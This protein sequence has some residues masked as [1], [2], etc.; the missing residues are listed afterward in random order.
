MHAELTLPLSTLWSFLLVLTRVGGALLFV[1]LPGI[2]SGPEP[3]RIVLALGFT[4]ALHPLWPR[5]AVAE[6]GLG[7][8][9][10]WLAAETALGVSVGVAVAFL[11]EGLLVACQVIGI[12]AGYSYA[13]LVDP[14]TQADSNVL[15]VLAHL[16]AGCLFFAFGL[17]RQVLRIFAASLESFPPGTFTLR[18][19]AAES[20][21]GLGA[22]MFT[23]GM[24]LALPVVAL[25]ALADIMLALLGRVHAQLQLLMLA[26]P[27]KMLAALVLL[28][29]VSSL[30]VPL[31]RAGAERTMTALAQMVARVPAM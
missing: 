1:P 19:S 20:L 25:L 2:R 11:T 16:M 21:L 3:S 14:A 13:A 12:Q 23:T 9:L 15:Q 28:A 22:G 24:R 30:A 8:L 6:P 4:A 5:L 27:V 31:F 18:W 29:T 26:F 10:L 7:Q 17:D